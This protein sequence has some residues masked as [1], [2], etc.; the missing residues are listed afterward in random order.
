MQT[1]PSSSNL[2][3]TR[4]QRAI[5]KHDLDALASCF[6]VDYVNDAPVHPSR[7]F[8]GRDQVRKNWVQIFAAVPDIKADLLCCTRAGDTVWTEWE[9]AGTRIDGRRHLM[10]GVSV[11]KEK[12]GGHSVDALLS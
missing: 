1:G 2:V 7:S 10:R 3:A 6:A 9:M 11:M 12:D 4:L 8:V 5:N